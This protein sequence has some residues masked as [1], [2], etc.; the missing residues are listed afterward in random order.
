MSVFGIW[1]IDVRK[2][3]AIGH[4][5]GTS[6]R[7]N[8]A[9]EDFWASAALCCDSRYINHPDWYFFNPDGWAASLKVAVERKPGWIEVESGG[10]GK[11]RLAEFLNETSIAGKIFARSGLGQ[12]HVVFLSCARWYFF[13]KKIKEHL[14]LN[15]ELG[16]QVIYCA[17]ARLQRLSPLVTKASNLRSR[18][19]YSIISIIRD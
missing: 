2:V 5:S 15:V 13:L 12:V 7:K 6:F 18:L 19:N 14:L 10:H 8:V 3:D 1:A 16:V 17:K 9:V 11:S 4:F